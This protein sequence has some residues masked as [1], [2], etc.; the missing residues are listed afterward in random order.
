VDDDAVFVLL[1]GA[2][3]PAL[4]A[5]GHLALVDVTGLVNDAATVRAGV[6]AGDDLLELA[7]QTVLVPGCAN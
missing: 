5:G 4:Y 6:L 1:H 3:V 7:W 2:T